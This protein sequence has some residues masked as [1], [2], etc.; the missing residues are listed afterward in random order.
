MSR[1]RPK[2][3]P[4]WPT[5]IDYWGD[6]DK[7]FRPALTNGDVVALATLAF[8]DH[9]TADRLT[10]LVALSEGPD[11]VGRLCAATVLSRMHD[12]VDEVVFRWL[13]E[14][15]KE[16]PPPTEVIDELVQRV[17]DQRDE[18]RASVVLA[19]LAQHQ[20]HAALT[21]ARTL[22]DDRAPGPLPERV[23][24]AA[25]LL[26]DSDEPD[27]HTRVLDLALANAR[28]GHRP[29]TDDLV[30]HLA[31]SEHD[32][33]TL[34]ELLAV[35]QSSGQQPGPGLGAALD[36][37]SFEQLVTR[38]TRLTLPWSSSDLLPRLH[39]RYPDELL[40]S[41]GDTDRWDDAQR[42]W[43][44]QQLPWDDHHLQRM[45]KLVPPE[46]SPERY[47]SVIA[48]LSNRVS[49]TA[50]AAGAAREMPV[51]GARL[52]IDE[53][54]AG[55]L[56]ADDPQLKVLAQLEPTVRLDRY[57]AALGGK[58]VAWR[59]A[60]RAA[61][62]ASLIHHVDL[63]DALRLAEALTMLRPEVR[64]KL[65]SHLSPTP[66]LAVELIERF[67]EDPIGLAALA[68]SDAGASA[69]RD[70]WT[71]TEDMAAFRALVAIDATPLDTIPDAIRTYDNALADPDRVELLGHLQDHPSGPATA[72][73]ILGDHNRHPGPA[74]DLLATSV[75]LLRGHDNPTTIV[76][77]VAPLCRHHNDLALRQA[78]YH[79]LG[80][81]DPI[82]ELIALLL[83]RRNDET[84]KA[85]PAVDAAISRLADSL[86]IAITDRG[87]LADLQALA[88]LAPERALPHARRLRERLAGDAGGRRIVT[89]ILADHGHSDDDVRVLAELA[90]DDPDLEVRRAAEAGQRRLTVGDL[91]GA[92]VRLGQIAGRDPTTWDHLDPTKLYDN[93]GEMLRAGLDRIAQHEAAGDWGS[94][95]DQLGAEVT[96]VVVYRTVQVV[97]QQ[98]GL[99]PPE[100]RAAA[101]NTAD[102]GAIVT[103]GALRQRWR[104]LVELEA[105]YRLRTEH[106]APKG[107]TTPHPPASEE[108]Y[109]HALRLFRSGIGPLLEILAAHT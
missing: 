12:D 71:A 100:V 11:L 67:V 9:P 72:L 6:D 30:K 35:Y 15:G 50:A 16:T 98:T 63:D 51:L 106:V 57:R 32:L 68:E 76:S 53:V 52:L 102:Y 34:D 84:P 64:A 79:L 18:A 2:S 61:R 19:W 8:I 17:H 23:I 21:C 26:A 65:L 31:A 43:L 44:I 88:R 70:R 93:W 27:D 41:L 54:V 38:A 29:V 89:R 49:A 37:L 5:V 55:R 4:L 85:R 90:T 60:D 103:H 75:L 78:T 73:V 94:A 92:H 13:P 1:G 10:D 22:L 99:K 83:E 36:Q 59:K 108:D 77:A 47:G 86:D 25:G 28:A 20:P 96:K 109:R 7:T 39:R 82:P 80:T 14:H 46:E 69:L 62:L 3:P 74:T 56:A 33:A 24:V 97:G 101:N 104:S 48:R 45:L 87:D 107:T 40:A 58:W 105:L 91:Y 42:S 81:I 66:E 95:I